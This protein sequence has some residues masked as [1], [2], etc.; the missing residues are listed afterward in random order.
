MVI[1]ISRLLSSCDSIN[2]FDCSKTRNA[3]N[4]SLSTD[5]KPTVLYADEIIRYKYSEVD[6]TKKSYYNY[7]LITLSLFNL[8][9]SF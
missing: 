9:D 8:V 2:T 1:L 3:V 7:F 6:I 4:V 5:S